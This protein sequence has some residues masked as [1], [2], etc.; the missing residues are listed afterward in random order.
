MTLANNCRFPFHGSAPMTKRLMPVT[1]FLLMLGSMLVAMG[2]NKPAAKA[3]DLS[4]KQSVSPVAEAATDRVMVYYF[5][6]TRRCPTCLGI[7]KNIEQTVQER[8]GAEASAKKLVFQAVNI[9]EDV[10]KPFVQQFQ[11]AFSTMIVAHMKGDKTLEWENCDK[12]WEFGHEAERLK[13]YTAERI[14]VYLAKLG[15]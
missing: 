11:I 8:F 4:Q 12:V 5:H 15:A 13:D 14:K 10:N 2:C 3:D 6:M 9:D 1:L 7:Q